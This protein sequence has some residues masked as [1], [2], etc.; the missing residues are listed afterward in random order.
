M[1]ADYLENEPLG[2]A[3][4]IKFF[5]LFYK[6]E[7]L[8]SEIFK[9]ITLR[10][11]SIKQKALS[12]EDPPS[13]FV[14]LPWKDTWYIPGGESFAAK[15]IEDAG[16]SYVYKDLQTTEAEPND[17]ESVYSR[18][19]D[20]DIWLNAGVAKDL[21]SILNHDERLGNIQAFEKGDVFNNNQ[22]SNPNGGNDYWESGNINP[23]RILNDLVNIFS[24]DI[25]SLF[26]YKRLR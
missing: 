10:Y 26:Y 1:C 19:L 6:R 3:E 17:L 14:G 24:G 7:D 20:A 22:R 21:Q 4:W 8:A 13:V 2:R 9:R 18:I 16:G 23:D 11:E 25:D 12:L 5:S 15:F